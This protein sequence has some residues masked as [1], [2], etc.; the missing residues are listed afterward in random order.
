VEVIDVFVLHRD[1]PNVTIAAFAD[2]PRSQLERGAI[3]SIGPRR[4]THPSRKPLG[5]TRSTRMCRS[6][7]RR[8]MEARAR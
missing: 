6:S 5:G 8:R 2:A 1:D 4:D 7:R 3:E